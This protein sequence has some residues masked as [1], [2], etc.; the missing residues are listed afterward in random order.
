MSPPVLSVDRL[1]TAMPNLTSIHFFHCQY[2]EGV[3]C[4][5]S[6]LEVEVTPDLHFHTSNASQF[7]NQ[8]LV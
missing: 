2:D 7:S 3:P 8:D 4:S 1:A 6:C 5:D